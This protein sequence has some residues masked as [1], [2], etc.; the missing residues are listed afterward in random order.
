VRFCL[1]LVIGCLMAGPVAALDSPEGAPAPTPPETEDE[2]LD[3]LARFRFPVGVGLGLGVGTILGAATS[4]VISAPAVT[5]TAVD[6]SVLISYR[7]FERFA[8]ELAL[9]EGLA[10]EFLRSTIDVGAR[11]FL[12]KGR[13]TTSLR[14][15]YVHI[16]QELLDDALRHLLPS[17][18]GSSRSIDH[19]NGFGA[20]VGLEFP[21]SI[22]RRERLSRLRPFLNLEL[23][24]TWNG[25]GPVPHGAILVSAGTWIGLGRRP[26]L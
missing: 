2:P 6:A 12:G 23:Y 10:G 8:P 16:H 1:A 24:L 4:E 21:R 26:E 15:S 19:R 20:G 7:G 13:I 3:D 9:R 25:R 11:L 14:A 22:T 17:V 5:R 18:I